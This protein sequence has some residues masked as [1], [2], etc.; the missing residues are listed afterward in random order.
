[1]ITATQMLNSMEHS[2]RPTR[3]E[4]SDVFNA[5]LD[6][7]DAVMFS[8]ESAVGEYPVEAVSMMRRICAEAEGYLKSKVRAAPGRR[9]LSA[10]SSTR[11]P[12]LRRR[13]LSDGAASWTP[14]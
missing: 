10:D 9:P 11:S 5:V 3:A 12:K 14:G 4:A 13:R 1:M 8:G 7:T 2:S 6:G